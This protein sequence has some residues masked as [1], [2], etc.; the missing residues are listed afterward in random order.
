[1]QYLAPN[2]SSLLIGLVFCWCGFRG[3]FCVR[4]TASPVAL[5]LPTCLVTIWETNNICPLVFCNRRRI[6]L[7]SLNRAAPHFA[8]Q[9]LL[10]VL[11]HFNIFDNSDSCL[12]IR[13]ESNENTQLIEGKKIRYRVLELTFAIQHLKTQWHF[14][15]MEYLSFFIAS[16]L[17]KMK[18]IHIRHQKFKKFTFWNNIFNISTPMLSKFKIFDRS[19]WVQWATLYHNTHRWFSFLAAIQ[20]CVCQE[21]FDKSL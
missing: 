11:P 7:F 18:Y 6:C 3:S 8:E 15:H 10:V 17:S 21:H 16:L 1:M 13:I 19:M 14:T 9:L 20:K 2:L 4:W 12:L 5:L